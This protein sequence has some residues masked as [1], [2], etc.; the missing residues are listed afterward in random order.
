MTTRIETTDGYTHVLDGTPTDPRALSEVLRHNL[1]IQG[2]VDS[3][4]RSII[5]TSEGETVVLTSQN[6]SVTG[7]RIR[8]RGV[9]TIIFTRS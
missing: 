6:P 8:A 9:T 5:T 1:R 4:I 2:V 3:G 7:D